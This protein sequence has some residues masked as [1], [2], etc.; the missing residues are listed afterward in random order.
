[1]EEG[2]NP[3]E[4]K[5]EAQ[6]QSDLLDTTISETKAFYALSPFAYVTC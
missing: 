5:K 3:G 6:L 4:S 1:M 2:Y